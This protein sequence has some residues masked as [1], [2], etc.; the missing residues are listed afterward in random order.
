MRFLVVGTDRESGERIEMAVDADDG[1][2]A[3]SLAGRRNIRVVSIQPAPP[4]APAPSGAQIAGPATRRRN[5][6]YGSPTRPARVKPPRVWLGL[7]L[8]LLPIS[9]PF[10][11]GLSLWTGVALASLVALYLLAP[12]LRRGLRLAFRVGPERPVRGGL[13]LATLLLYGGVLVLVGVGGRSVRAEMA[14][15]EHRRIAERA[16]QA[17]RVTAATAQVQS[18][19]AQAKQHLDAGQVEQAARCVEQARGVEYATNRAQAASLARKISQSGDAAHVM[20]LLVSMSD[21]EFSQFRDSGIVT[22]SLDFGV[23]VLSER[24]IQSARSQ[25]TAAAQMREERRRQAL[26]EAEAQRLREFADAEA[27]RRAEEEKAAE[28]RMRRERAQRAVKEKLDAYV[29]LLDRADVSIVERVSVQRIDDD[30]WEA[31]I[32]VQNLW[33]VRAYQMRLQD[34]Q[35]LWEAWAGIASPKDPDKARIKI[36]DLRDNE[37][38]GS[39]IW[40]GSLIWVQEK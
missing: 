34:A 18:L 38:G 10:V 4:S 35:A 12:P 19:V 29:A 17:R 9:A 24:A 6:G 39:R 11:P 26:A 40:G 1:E 27:K 2:V 36:A 15:S 13:K 20:D 28:E 37:V 8:L 32:T 31:T 23:P 3:A 33:H 5:Q 30:T 14:A 7:V 22:A 21:E 16:E 25:V